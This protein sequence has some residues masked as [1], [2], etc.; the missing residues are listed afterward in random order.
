MIT[1]P[2]YTASL[3]GHKA[4]VGFLHLN[5]TYNNA[6]VHTFLFLLSTK[7]LCNSTPLLPELWSLNQYGTETLF[8]EHFPGYDK[9]FNIPPVCSALAR[10]RWFVAYTL[11]R[12]PS[13]VPLTARNI[14]MRRRTEIM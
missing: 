2:S 6:V 7:H 3:I 8:Y 1:V 12:N 4:Y 10:N 14:R 11:V 9:R 5:H 13:L